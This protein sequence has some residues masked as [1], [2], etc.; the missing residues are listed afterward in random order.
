MAKKT[1]K[2]KNLLIVESPAKAKT[3]NKYLGTDFKVMA[4]VGHVIDLPKSKLGVDVENGYEPLFETI[5]G[6]GKILKD[7]K[8]ALPKDGN[9]YLAMD[10]DREGEAIAWHIEHSLKIKDAKRVT[11]HEITKDAILES[12]KSPT[13]VNIDL[14][15]AQKARR[16][17]DR[18]F[19]YKLSEVLWNK[20]WYGL[21]AG[22]VQSV[23]LRLVV[24]RE[25]EREAFKPEEYWE[26]FVH[27]KKE[28]ERLAIKLLRKDGKKYVPGS[29]DEVED[30]K[31]TLEDNKYVVVDIVKKEMKKNPY[32]PYTTSTLQQA[33][34]NVLGFSAKKT[35]TLAQAL[36][37]SGYITYMRTDSIYLSEKAI[38]EIRTLI[39][40]KYGKEYLPD[41]PRYYKNRS[42]N[43][44]EA[45]EAIR[46]SDFSVTS[47]SIRTKMGDAQARL[48]DL[49]WKRAVSCQMKPK[50]VENLS[51]YFEPEKKLKNIYTFSV[52][53]QKVLFDGFRIVYGNGNDSE[54]LL[55]EI[56]NVKKGDIFFK[57][58]FQTDQK[59]TQPPAR[60]TEATLV[61]KLESLGVGRPS[62]YATIISTIQAREYVKKDGKY[63]L[64]TDIGRVVTHFLKN[65]F[66]DLIDYKY[67]ADVEDKLDDIAQGKVEYIPFMDSV[68]K[69]LMED[70]E[71]TLKEVNKEDVVILGKSD[72]KCPVCGGEMVVRL[73]RY[74]KFLS[75][76]KFPECKGMKDLSGGEESL[77]FEKY[78]KVEKCPEC[79]S[80]MILKNSR[81][82]KFWA[83]VKYPECKGT[84]SLLLNEKCPECGRNLV[85]RKSKWGKIFKGCSGYPDCKYIKKEVKKKEES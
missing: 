48:Y 66:S 75:C 25:E 58:K 13:K 81:Y 23:A 59:F 20:I 51:I 67:T 22:R 34:N 74:G 44:Q 63:L 9:T 17:L 19:G 30:I 47:S 40:N 62:T 37:Q 83:C 3:I 61:K 18:L 32:P 85:E 39:P 38:N 24:E 15:E 14:V 82:G 21:S 78:L 2:V 64:P 76:V 16:V 77:D 1:S 42:K 43:A 79:G 53:A 80:K 70:I 29:K 35:M 69:P 26:F 11:F 73:G 54:E 4:T 28:K 50:E 49:I 72:E 65:N 60:Y 57:E 68:Y 52:G 56:S 5:Y 6:K 27:V 8:K 41:V 55:Q 33:A 36:Y 71:K 7:L 45:H 31:K 84:V 12:M 10:P 46:P